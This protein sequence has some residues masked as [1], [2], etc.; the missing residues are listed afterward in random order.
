M[1]DQF[2][3]VILHV[4]TNDLVHKDAELVATEMDRLITET[5]SKARK[6]AV[7]SVVKGYDG[8]AAASSITHFKNLVS[9]LSSQHNIVFLNNDHIDK[10]LLNRS[11]LH[12]NQSG[13]RALGSVFCNYLKSNRVKI[14]NRPVNTR[15]ERVDNVS[16]ICEPDDEKVDSHNIS[17]NAGSDFLTSLNSVPSTRGFKMAFL[18]IVSLPKN[19]DEIRYLMSSKHIDLIA[20]NETRLDSNLN[21]NMVHIN[22]YDIIRKNRSRSGGGVCIYLRNSINYKVRHDLIP[23]ELE[24]VCI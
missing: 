4:G 7:S 18:N 14:N 5:K 12:L 15:N 6:V 21:N 9:N 19:L 22:N 17:N 16:T 20:F 23:T 10:S 1:K 13:D 8:R 24:C 11:D 2:E 3:T